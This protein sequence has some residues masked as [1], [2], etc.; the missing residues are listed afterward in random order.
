LYE[1]ELEM[2]SKEDLVSLC[3]ELLTEMWNDGTFSNHYIVTMLKD[4]KEENK[5]E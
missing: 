2:L 5:N 4:K 3:N 1:K